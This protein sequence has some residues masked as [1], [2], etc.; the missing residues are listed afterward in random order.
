MSHIF[1]ILY[2]S[3][4]MKGVTWIQ[5]Q[6]FNIYNTLEKYISVINAAD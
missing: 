5:D 4:I 3:D 2:N 6:V 1:A